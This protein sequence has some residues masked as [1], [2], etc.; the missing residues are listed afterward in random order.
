MAL[1]RRSAVSLTALAMS[2]AVVCGPTLTASADIALTIAEAKEQIKQLEADAAALDQ[3]YAGVKD[4]IDTGTKKLR[5]KQADVQAQTKKVAQ[6]RLQVGQVALAQFQNRNLDTTA[7]LF[8]TSDTDGFLS[9][10][11]TVEKISENQNR[12]LQSFQSEQA[13]LADLQRSTEA[14]L[15]ALTK[16][17]TELAQL[18]ASSDKKL[19]ESKAVL[20]KLTEEER[21]RL[22]AEEKRIADEAAKAAAA[23]RAALDEARAGDSSR[24]S[25][26][27]GSSSNSERSSGSSTRSDKSDR[28]VIA[29]NFAE[30]QVGKPYRFGAAGPDAFDCSGLTSAAWERAGVSLPRTSQQQFNVGTPVAKSDLRRGDLVFF[31]PPALSH[32]GLYAGN[33]TVL[34]A[35]N[36]RKPVGYLDIDYMP[37]AGARRPG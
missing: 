33:G 7:Q 16:Q 19:A 35:S 25:K 17:R 21:R 31:Y 3:D 14:D 29:L 13:T 30:Q 20:A 18:R 37:W 15:A 12:V 22:A 4:Q 26:R 8:F 28:G 32:V 6:I 10:I 5:T 1:L 24:S 27:Q 34:H 23:A 2:A 11:S 9:Q 36:P